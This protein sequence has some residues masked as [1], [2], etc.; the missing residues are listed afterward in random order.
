M[1]QIRSFLLLPLVVVLTLASCGRADSSS[2]PQV[3]LAEPPVAS[4]AVAESEAD[5]GGGAEDRLEVTVEG[6]IFPGTH[7]VTGDM[8]CMMYGGVWQAVHERQGE[9]GLSGML[10][11][12]KEIPAA[13][14]ATDRLS[15]SLTFGDMD[16][17]SGTAR[18]LDLAGSESGGDGR[19][20]VTR[21]GAGAVLRVEG[22]AVQGG[23]VTAV[24]RCATVDLM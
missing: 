20:T 14:G 2:T 13:G 5:A 10:L 12:L 4:P 22:T 9:A 8:S 18:L 17:M 1:F 24:L 16:D 6:A 21:E 23:R 11:Q 3:E 15:F 19:G 7:Q